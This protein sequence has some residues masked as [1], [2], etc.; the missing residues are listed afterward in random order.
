MNIL[1]A[2]IPVLHK[3]YLDLFVNCNAKYLYIIGEEVISSFKELDYVTRKDSLRSVPTQTIRIMVESLGIFE[4]VKIADSNK[5]EF[6]NKT[7]FKITMP[8][9][10]VSISVAERYLSEKE[11]GFISIFLR[12]NIS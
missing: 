5:L 4:K 8:R 1:I 7:D 9:E 10:D 3:G 6:L 12:W 2:Y 11:I